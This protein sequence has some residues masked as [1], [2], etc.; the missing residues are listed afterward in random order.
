MKELDFRK[1]AYETV[2]KSDWPTNQVFHFGRNRDSRF[3]AN[4]I[5]GVS[6]ITA[7]LEIQ[8]LNVSDSGSY[9]CRVE[10]R[11]LNHQPRKAVILRES[12]ISLKI[13]PNQLPN[14]A[15]PLTPFH[16]LTITFMLVHV[17]MLVHV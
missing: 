8:E 14:A 6:A 17:Y 5:I 12:V 15:I 10:P 9:Y 4:H 16:L 1:S 11:Y 7:E 13:L 2:V 3:T